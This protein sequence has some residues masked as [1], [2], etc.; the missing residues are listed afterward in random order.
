[1][2]LS[3]AVHAEVEQY[4]MT[5]TVVPPGPVPSGFQQPSDAG[6][7][8]DRL[9]GFTFVSAERV[10]RD[11]LAAA[12]KGKI[13]VIPGGPQVKAVLGPNRKLPRFLTLPVSKRMMARG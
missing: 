7:L 6:Y 8:A 9:P 2:L 13:S 10:A 3:E 4:G 1:L 11:A 5:I 12:D